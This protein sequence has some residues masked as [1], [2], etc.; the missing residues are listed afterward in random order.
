MKISTII[1]CLI[2]GGC[3]MAAI[4]NAAYGFLEN[5][6]RFTLLVVGIV[7]MI[8]AIVWGGEK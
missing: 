2:G 3:L 1:M 6:I 7:L 8:Y 5:F 4:H